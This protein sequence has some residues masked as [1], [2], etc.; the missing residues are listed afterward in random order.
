MISRFIFKLYENL[1]EN[2]RNS[3]IISVSNLKR[4][5]KKEIYTKCFNYF[6]GSANNKSLNFYSLKNYLVS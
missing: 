4:E 3:L 2:L 5:F 1:R 6:V